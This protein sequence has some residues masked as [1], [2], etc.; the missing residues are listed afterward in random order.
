[1][2]NLHLN[3]QKFL[4]KNLNNSDGITIFTNTGGITVKYESSNYTNAG[5]MG[6]AH[7]HQEVYDISPDIE[8]GRFFT[9]AESAAGRNV[10][11]VGHKDQT[12][13]VFV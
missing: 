10:A 2:L 1:M 4:K 11:I 5:L 6:V 9:A 13:R 3:V 12:L 7:S 8:Q